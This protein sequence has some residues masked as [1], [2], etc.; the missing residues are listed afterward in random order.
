[1]T[2]RT[3]KSIYYVFLVLFFVVGAYLLMVTQGL[4]FDWTKLRLVKTGAIY[5]RTTPPNASILIDKK[6]YSS[7][8]GFLSQG[9][10]IKDLLPDTYHAEVFHD[11]YRD[12]QKDLTVEDGL[13][14]SASQ[15]KLWKTEYP[16][17]EIA[18]SSVKDFFLTE[19]GPVIQTDDDR[20]LFGE[21]ELK[22]SS[23]A[24]TTPDS[25][26]V[27]TKDAKGNY[28]LTD[29]D[30][31]KSSLNVSS[32]FPSLYKRISTSTS[33]QKITAVGFHPFSSSKIFIA[34][35]DGVYLLDLKKIQ[36][37]E[38]V[39]L[40]ETARLIVTENEVFAS[41][42]KG[43]FSGTNLLIGSNSSFSIATSSIA[44]VKTN[45][46]GT[47]FFILE[48]KGSLVEYDRSA[49]TSTLIAKNVKD[50]FLSPEE[51]RMLIVYDDNTMKLDYLAEA[52]GDLHLSK[53]TLTP[54]VIPNILKTAKISA[55]WMPDV[56]GYFLVAVNGDIFAV[57]TDPRSP[58]NTYLLFS[59][60][61]KYALQGALYLLKNNGA[62]ATVSL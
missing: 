17:T 53:G 60:I 24:A 5:L 7:E 56:P 33:T 38:V 30:D 9:T 35:R 57:E 50:F 21:N 2:L 44:N 25:T 37:E 42:D 13:V 23:V 48:K 29:L 36:L 47:K 40:K 34:T 3:R 11:G 55:T 52:T 32:L 10:L 62:F 46:S 26:E 39:T 19:K 1:M 41:D 6:P 18:S 51:K 8:S 58:L 20:I 15:I 12:W 16:E 61:K 4:V 31:M 49:S 27:V 22:G 59:H 45:P 54:I 28:I 43:A 14:A